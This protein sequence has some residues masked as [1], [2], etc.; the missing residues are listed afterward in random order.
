MT[1]QEY[2]Q[3]LGKLVGIK[4]DSD[5]DLEEQ[6]FG[7]FQEF[8]PYGDNLEKVFEPLPCGAELYERIKPIFK[9]TQSDFLAAQKEN[10]TPMY[11][12]PPK[13]DSTSELYALAESLLIGLIDFAKFIKAKELQKLLSKITNIEISQNQEQDFDNEANIE[14]YEVLSIWLIDNTDYDS[15]ILLLQEAYYS[16]ANDYFL[17]AYLQYPVLIQKP[18]SDFLKPYFE[19][20]K[21]GYHFVINDDK[22]IL[23]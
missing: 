17:S 14:L 2:A 10:C 11:F 4:I 8:M 6:F 16:V 3:Y 5:I 12:I 18:N 1:Q 22:L 19:I 15:L 13:S 9:A 20:W 21:V 7:Y 23:F